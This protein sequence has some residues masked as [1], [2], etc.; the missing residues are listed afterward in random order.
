M[1]NALNVLNNIR[2][3]RAQAR[4]MPLSTLEEILEKLTAV[5]EESRDNAKALS[6]QQ[7]ERD[8]KLLKYRE[9]LAN[10]GIAIDDL[11]GHQPVKESTK[12]KRKPRPAIYAYTDTDGEKKT[13]T[14]QGR[15]PSAIKAALDGGA[16]LESF[17]IVR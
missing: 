12:A 16:T 8:E 10:D 6:A 1:D 2:T 3:L 4:E 11:L 15:T 9:M 13:W 7:Q 14:G 17:L 5:V